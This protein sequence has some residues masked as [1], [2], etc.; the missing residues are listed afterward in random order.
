MKTKVYISRPNK[1]WSEVDIPGE[2]QQFSYEKLVNR[3][4]AFL[5][6]KNYKGLL[7][8]ENPAPFP[9]LKLKD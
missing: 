3:I 4:H 6:R 8:T 7:I 9:G 2:F 1:G 5:N